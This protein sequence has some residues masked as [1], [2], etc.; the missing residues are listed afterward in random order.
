MISLCKTHAINCLCSE[1]LFLRHSQITSDQIMP[2][3][4]FYHLS[5]PE[6]E[7]FMRRKNHKTGKSEQMTFDH[8]LT[9]G[10]Q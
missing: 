10:N 9:T 5:G 6:M 3:R 2:V 4:H 7:E 1:I 8:T